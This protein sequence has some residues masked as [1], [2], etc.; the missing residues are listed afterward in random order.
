MKELTVCIPTYKDYHGVFFTLQAL[1]IYHDRKLFDIVVVDNYGCVET[2][3]L[4]ENMAVKY[5]LVISASGPSNVKNVAIDACE[6]IYFLCIDSHVL[7][8]PGAVE[9]LLDYYKINPGTNNLLHGPLTD[10]AGNIMATQMS[11]YWDSQMYG[12]W[13]ADKVKYQANEPFE[14]TMHGM[15]AFSMRKAAWPGFN[16][17]FIGFGGEEGYIHD[18]VRQRGGK[19]ICVPGFKWTHRFEQPEGRAYRLQTYDR[20][21]NYLIGRQELG[22]PV[23]DVVEHFAAVIGPRELVKAFEEARIALTNN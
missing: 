17:S 9:S 19:C 15:G 22:K 6:T 20:V 8:W 21:V 7:L 4:C 16:K 12:V 13:W 10:D 14:I 5:K 11:P 2:K 18:K 23:D 3:R 1:N